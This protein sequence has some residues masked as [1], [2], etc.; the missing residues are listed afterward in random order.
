MNSLKKKLPVIIAA[1]AIAA[2]ALTAFILYQGGQIS[3]LKQTI[4]DKSKKLVL[5]SQQLN[6][7]I[8]LTEELEQSLQLYKDSLSVLQLENQQLHA[9]IEELKGTISRLNKVIQKQDDKVVELT[10]EINR[11]KEGGRKKA[12]Q[13]KELEQRREELLIKMETI[14]KER[15]ALLNNCIATL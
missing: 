3:T 6:E 7:Q 5:L 2:L 1:S 4:L 11:L 10:A 13:V 9:K 15:I 8:T 12:E 14:D